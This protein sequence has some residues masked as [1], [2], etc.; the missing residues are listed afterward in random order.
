M[1]GF[2]PAGDV[3]ESDHHATDEVVPGAVGQLTHSVP[4]AI[5]G[6]NIQFL[7]LPAFQHLYGF[8]GDLFVKNLCRNFGCLAPCPG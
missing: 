1:L 7:P 2:F 4:F 8:V 3:H 5:L 6:L